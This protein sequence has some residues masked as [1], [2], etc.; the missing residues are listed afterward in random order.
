M[1]Q[2]LKVVFYATTIMSTLAACEGCECKDAVKG[3]QAADLLVK[4]FSA[5][6]NNDLPNH[7]YYT[8]IHQIINAALEVACPEELSDAGAHTDNLTMLFSENENFSNPSIVGTKEASVTSS[9]P[10]DGTYDVESKIEFTMDGYYVIAYKLDDKNQVSERDEANNEGEDNIVPGNGRT[11]PYKFSKSQ[12]I[13]VRNTNSRC[14]GQ[15]KYYKEWTVNV[16][17]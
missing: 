9:T 5:A 15:C 4:D 6:F 16:V 11:M 2:T 17:Q 8:T 3:V 7:P 10:P 1:N 14:K 12:V 13:R